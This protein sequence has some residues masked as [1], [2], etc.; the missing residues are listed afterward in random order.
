MGYIR[1]THIPNTL[2]C[3]VDEYDLDVVHIVCST[4][5]RRATALEVIAEI[6]GTTW[7]GDHEVEVVLELLRGLTVTAII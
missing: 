2:L 5:G 3:L 6:D 7:R 4:T 1:H